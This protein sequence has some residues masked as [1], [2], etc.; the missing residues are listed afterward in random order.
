MRAL[1]VDMGGT[2][3]RVALVTKNDYEMIVVDGVN[4]MSDVDGA[5]QA[6]VS[7]TEALSEKVNLPISTLEASPAYLGVAGVIEPS[8]AQALRIRLPFEKAKIEDDRLSSLRGAL[9]ARDGYVIH[10]GTGSFFAKQENSEAAFAGGWGPVLDDLAGAYWVGVQALQLTL[11]AED[12]L[13]QH[14]SMT[15]HILSQFGSTAAIVMF[16]KNASTSEVGH[17]AKSVTQHALQD[18]TVAI[19]VLRHGAVLVVEKLRQF[20]WSEGDAICL[21]G[22]IAS[23]YKPYLPV[24]VQ[25]SLVDALG[26]PL[27][28]SIALARAFYQEVHND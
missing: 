5:A 18:D 19:S 7:G 12:G 25:S 28:G 8:I 26:D 10:C 14:S 2:H 17:L 20:G 24:S 13:E 1:A 6:I 16:A 21:T 27:E 3:C 11:Y 23:S 9:G 15:S 4:A 22:G